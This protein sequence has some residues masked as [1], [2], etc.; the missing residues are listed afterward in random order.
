M[1]N[2]IRQCLVEFDLAWSTYEQYYVYELMVIETDARRFIIESI[3]VEKE[4]R[5]LET[6]P[7]TTMDQYNSKRQELVTYLSQINAI[8]NV[9]GKGR[10]DLT[11]L[12][13]LFAAEKIQKELRTPGQA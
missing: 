8:C 5:Q 12:S 10:D 6:T 3:K 2:Q 13:I 4:L 9:N 11:D 7:G 1:Q